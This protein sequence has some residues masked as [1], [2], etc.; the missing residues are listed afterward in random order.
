MTLIVLQA[1]HA[2]AVNELLDEIDEDTFPGAVDSAMISMT[3]QLGAPDGV[4]SPMSMDVRLF[5][6]QLEKVISQEANGE[7][8]SRNTIEFLFEKACRR[9]SENLK[10]ELDIAAFIARNSDILRFPLSRDAAQLT[11]F[12]QIKAGLI[13]D[14]LEV[15]EA[16]GVDDTFVRQFPDGFNALQNY[17]TAALDLIAWL[18]ENQVELAD[19]YTFDGLR[20]NVGHI[21]NASNEL[22]HFFHEMA[23]GNPES[24]PIYPLF[25]TRILL[26]EQALA[27]QDRF[28]A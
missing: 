21:Q 12:D 3:A 18:E 25:A 28:K 27:L 14:Y 5:W 8:L 23:L 16:H 6:L 22:L 11:I 2:L 24:N 15:T 17:R 9:F 20:S 4:I 26:A 7:L 1:G 13:A 10:S 19:G